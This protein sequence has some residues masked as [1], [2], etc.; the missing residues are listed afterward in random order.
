MSMPRG[1]TILAAS[2]L[3]NSRQGFEWF[4]Q[5]AA[6]RQPQLITFLGD[7]ITKQ[8]MAFVKEVLLSLRELA[9]NCYVIPGNWDPREVLV[10]IDIAAID[11]LRN[12]H[13]ASAWLNGYTFAGLGGSITTPP[14]NTP[15]EAPD[16]GFA[17]AF[18]ALLP[19]DIWLLH[20]PIYGYRDRTTRGEFAGSHSLEAQWQL[21]DPPPVL[22]LSGHIHE[23]HGTEQARGTTFVNPGS[24][25]N[26]CAAWVELLES[27]AVVELLRGDDE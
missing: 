9:P 5:L 25:A 20:N 1:L 14:G 27:T 18:A 21:Q 4:C 3:H 2:D 6:Q 12:L 7:F 13:K 8:P 23:A 24:L 17:G 16:Q 11:G 26:R 22:V 19:A 10:E 15:M